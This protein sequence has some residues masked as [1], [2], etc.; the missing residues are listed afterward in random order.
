[1]PL[2]GGATENPPLNPMHFIA[3]RDTDIA[4]ALHN[5]KHAEKADDRVESILPVTAGAKSVA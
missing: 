4:R 2:V 1:M 5:G 3:L